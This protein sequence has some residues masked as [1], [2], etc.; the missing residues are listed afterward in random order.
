MEPFTPTTP[1]GR[2]QGIRLVFK[3]KSF[4]LDYTC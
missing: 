4:S 2:A 3:K 1:Q